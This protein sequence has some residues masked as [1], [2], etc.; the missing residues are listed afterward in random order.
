MLY[1]TCFYI[2]HT[3]K[4]V[5]KEKE[6]EEERKKREFAAFISHIR[7]VDDTIKNKKSLPRGCNT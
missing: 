4:K 7:R 6:E 1:W 5:Y 2:V 3:Q